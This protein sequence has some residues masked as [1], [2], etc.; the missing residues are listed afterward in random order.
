MSEADL[1]AGLHARRLLAALCS[2]ST[3][4]L[5]TKHPVT[6]EPGDGSLGTQPLRVVHWARGRRVWP[7]ISARLLGFVTHTAALLGFCVY[8]ADHLLPLPCP[9][10]AVDFRDHYQE[11]EMRYRL[12]T[13]DTEAWGGCGL[14][15]VPLRQDRLTRSFAPEGFGAD[16]FLWGRS[17][18]G[19]R[20]ARWCHSGLCSGGACRG[21]VRSHPARTIPAHLSS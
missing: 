2:G 3:V 12:L 21:T 15:P 20:R 18:L 16:G 5:G 8:Q 13:L 6:R 17:R 11:I 4:F 10:P 9:L 1:P 19:R 14:L 7:L